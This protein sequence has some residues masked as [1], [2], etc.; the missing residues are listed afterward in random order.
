MNKIRATFR[1]ILLHWLLKEEYENLSILIETFKETE[2]RIISK[3]RGL[4]FKINEVHERSQK[5]DK[6]FDNLDISIDHHMNKYSK[7]WAVVS[8]QGGK[9]DF[10]QFF[11][12]GQ[13]DI[14]DIQNFLRSF[15]R[16]SNVKI[17]SF[18][19]ASGLFEIDRKKGKG[20]RNVQW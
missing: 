5:L 9:S 13:S 10:I 14:R 20:G 15:D 6:L 2:R 4:D 18:P 11:D 8:I 7:S 1:K 3:E 12:L 19:N 16:R 17:D